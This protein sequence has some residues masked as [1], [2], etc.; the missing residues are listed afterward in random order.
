ME[1][2]NESDIF[3]SEDKHNFEEEEDLLK[4]VTY[5]NRKRNCSINKMKSS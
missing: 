2:S 5:Y 1:E 4:K 3:V